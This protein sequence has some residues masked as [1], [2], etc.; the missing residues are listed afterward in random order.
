[1]EYDKDKVDE[2][3]LAILYLS[4]FKER[5][6]TRAWKTFDWDI[7]DRLHEKNYISDPKTTAKSVQVYEEA[8]QL[9]EEL[10]RKHF[11]AQPIKD[12]GRRSSTASGTNQNSQ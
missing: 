11:V 3:A 6:V 10:F 8:F 4:M 2:M 7:M 5:Y 12:R 9:A 1:M